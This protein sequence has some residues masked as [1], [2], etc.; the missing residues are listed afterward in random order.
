MDAMPRTYR[1]AADK[2]S[3]FQYLEI[4]DRIP[5]KPDYPNLCDFIHEMR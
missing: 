5:I 4:I 2:E 3:Q 1:S